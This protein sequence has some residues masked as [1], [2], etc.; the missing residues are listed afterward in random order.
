[1]GMVSSVRRLENQSRRAEHRRAVWRHRVGQ[2]MSRAKKKRIR[3]NLRKQRAH[4]DRVLRAGV[5]I[6]SFGARARE[7]LARLA[8]LRLCAE[9]ESSR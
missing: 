1:M 4:A 3:A 8:Y 2:A 6:H 9:V 5:V 7:V